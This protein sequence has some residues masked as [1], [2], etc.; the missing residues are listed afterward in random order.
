MNFAIVSYSHKICRK[1]H[2]KMAQWLKHL[3][4][5]LLKFGSLEST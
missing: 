1:A 4:Q 5:E 2:G 3:L